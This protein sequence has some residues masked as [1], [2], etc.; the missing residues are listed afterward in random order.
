MASPIRAGE[1]IAGLPSPPAE[2]GRPAAASP[3]THNMP[4]PPAAAPTAL[5][6]PPATL[7]FLADLVRPLAW[8]GA[9]GLLVLQPALTLLGAGGLASRLAQA[10]EHL[11]MPPRGPRREEDL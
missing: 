8:F 10:L 3:L 5:G 11:D 7:A 2:R 1:P 4:G 9:Q 6:L